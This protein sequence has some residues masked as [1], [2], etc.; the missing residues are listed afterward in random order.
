MSLHS[1]RHPHKHGGASGAGAGAAHGG[2]AQ[3]GGP[4]PGAAARAAGDAGTPACV[5][6]GDLGGRRN[7]FL[8]A[9]AAGVHA[10]PRDD[11]DARIAQLQR[12]STR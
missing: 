6:A 9:G 4:G 11:R 8:E 10:R 7:A 12:S 3:A 5:I 1:A 2:E